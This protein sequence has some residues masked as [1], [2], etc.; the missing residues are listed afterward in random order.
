MDIE[1]LRLHGVVPVMLLP[2]KPDESLDEEAFRRQVDFAIGAGAV[3]VCAPGFATEFYKISDSEKY[4]VAELLVQHTNGRV[5]AIIATGSGSVRTTVEFSRFAER[6]GAQGLMVAAPRWCALGAREL[7][8]FYEAVCD[9]VTLPVMLQDADFTGAGL[10]PQLLADLAARCSNFLFAKL[11][12]ALPGA[13]CAEIIR[14]TDGKVQVL[15]GKGG[16][17]MIDGLLHGATGVMPASA[18]VEV[19]ARVFQLWDANRREEATD[20]FYRLQPYLVFASQHLELFMKM[21]KAVLAR[22]GIFP[23]DRLREPTLHLDDAY[24]DEMEILVGKALQVCQGLGPVT[25][26]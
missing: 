6:I 17:E 13:K 16:L 8:A 26:E 11:E 24:Q 5:P 2:L 10:A 21:D 20:L 22:R 12:N 1:R 7:R 4:R 9:S 23:S 15:Y 18:L 14:L 3:A 25:G 19:Y